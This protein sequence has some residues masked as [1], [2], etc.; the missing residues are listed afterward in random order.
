MKLNSSNN[1]EPAIWGGIECTINR[2][3]DTYLDQLE[4]SGHYTREN[5]LEA[6]AALGIRTL[7]YPV[8]WEYHQPE[9]NKAIDFSWAVKQLNKLRE[10]QVTPIV[11]LVHH[12]SGPAFTSLLDERFPEK[13]AAYA[14]K[15]AEQF[16]WVEYYTPVNEP[17]TTARFSGLYGLWYPHKNN[18]V[19]CMKMLLNELK[20]VVLSMQAIRKINP[21]AK[22]VQTEDLGKTYSTS[23]LSY[24]ARFENHRRWLTFDLLCG[25][26]VKDHPLW[27]YF[28]RLGI[29]PATLKFFSD[30]PLPPDIIGVNH[31]ITSERFL[32]EKI[33]KY[34]EHTHGGNSLHVYADIEAIRVKHHEPHGFKVLM[35]EIWERYHL[36]LAVTEAH[37]HCSREEQLKWFKEIYDSSIELAA[38]GM[39]IAG[40]TA[41]SLFGAYGWNKLLAGTPCDYER[42]AFD[43]SAGN[44][45]PTAMA[46]L[47]RTLIEKGNFE[48]PVINRPGWW[49]SETRYFTKI[50]SQLFPQEPANSGQPILIIGKRGTLGR[51]FSRICE[52]RGLSYILLSRQDLDICHYEDIERTISYY[53][54]WAIINA[55]G[56]VRV[57]NAESDKLNCF[58]ENTR[59]PQQLAT[60]CRRYG[61]QFMTFSSDLVF[62][63]EKGA[64]YVESDKVN[65]LNIYGNSKA[66]A[67]EM[68][69]LLN[70]ATLIIR[71]SA[72]FGPWDQYNFIHHLLET[73][74]QGHTFNAAADNIIS[75]TYIPHLVNAA[76]D[77]LI[78][79][80]KGIWHVTNN[81]H[82]S[83][84]EFA[85]AAAA[86]A[87]K[88]PQRIR[89]VVKMNHVA[90]RPRYSVLQSEKGV[91]LPSLETAL[92][93]FF[94][95]KIMITG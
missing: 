33:E 68:V 40:V 39:N 24:Q 85:K 63:G 10:L 94:H 58:R 64:P 83:W 80:E 37:L 52:M 77:L 41:W 93:E 84:Y 5:D 62:D 43:V 36:P 12:G 44:V 30:N 20:A 78:D 66:K 28:K 81:G 60:A 3:G 76:L 13:L 6:I 65:P 45:R 70:P 48:S 89:H 21:Q 42:G 56:Y 2:V 90:R 92:E 32:D 15:V 26:V 67:E 1:Q 46:G 14:T 17:L 72:F 57:D 73:L 4:M 8:L 27:N 16:P 69:S 38:Q 54:P 47:L 59:G 51:A 23:L 7:R 25:K 82:V 18:D 50:R 19:S 86:K 75:P 11:G 55:A 34:P 22:L 29:T 35:K 79:D 91:L 71:T 9:E 74:E 95:E 53:N 87:G 31:Y 49:K 61:I 88:D